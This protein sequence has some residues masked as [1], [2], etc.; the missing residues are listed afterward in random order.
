MEQRQGHKSGIHADVADAAAV[1]SQDINRLRRRSSASHHEEGPGGL[2]WA[3]GAQVLCS[4]WGRVECCDRGDMFRI[5]RLD[6]RRL[7]LNEFDVALSLT[8]MLWMSFSM[9]SANGSLSRRWLLWHSRAC[10][11]PSSKKA[12]LLAA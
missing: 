10:A 12:I 5:F 2:G 1:T 9:P 6:L 7:N 11:T 3:I 4:A 8:P